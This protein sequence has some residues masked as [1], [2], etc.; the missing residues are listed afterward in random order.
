MNDETEELFIKALK[1]LF[2][3]WGGDTPAEAYWTA[4]ELLDYYESQNNVKLGIRFTT[5]TGEE[6]DDVVNAIRN[7]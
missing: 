5:E 6:F 2:F 7:S 4:N 1:T 3:S